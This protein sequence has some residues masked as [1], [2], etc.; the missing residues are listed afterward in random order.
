MHKIDTLIQEESYQLALREIKN[1]LVNEH[2]SEIRWRLNLRKGE[3]NRCRATVNI[4]KA[5]LIFESLLEESRPFLPEMLRLRRNLIEA[6]IEKRCFSLAVE[7][8]SH[9]IAA[10]GEA[11]DLL[12]CQ[13]KHA[14]AI[15]KRL[16]A[17]Y[18]YQRAI[19]LSK[20]NQLALSELYYLVANVNYIIGNFDEAKLNLSYIE[21]HDI[22][23]VKAQRLLA[24][25]VSAAN[26]HI[27]TID[28]L[29]HLTQSNT[30]SDLHA[31]D[32]LNL[33]LA[34]AA[35]GYRN[36]AL[37][38]FYKVAKNFEGCVEAGFAHA[39]ID[40]SKNATADAR[41]RRLWPFPTT[42][43]ERHSCAPAV[44]DLCLRYLGIELDS[45]YIAKNVLSVNGS[46][47]CD[48]V[49]FL[50]ENEIQA[51]RIEVTP[52]RLKSAIDLGLPVIVQEEYATTGHVAVITG[53]DERFD[54]FIANDPASHRPLLKT[55]AWI[56][57]AGDIY[58]NGG[59]I[60]LGKVGQ[61]SMIEE[62]ADAVG[63]KEASHLLML[64]DRQ[65]GRVVL[66]SD[67]QGD[68]VLGVGKTAY[69]E[70]VHLADRAL[71]I[72][73][74]FKL[75]W[76]ERSRAL[77][78][79]WEIHQSDEHLMR[80]TASIYDARSRFSGDKWPYLLHAHLLMKQEYYEEASIAYQEAS[81][82]DP[83]DANA[84]EGMGYAKLLAGDLAHAEKDLLGALKIDPTHNRAARHLAALYLRQLELLEGMRSKNEAPLAYAQIAIPKVAR[85]EVHYPSHILLK[86]ARH[87]A[88]VACSRS[89]NDAMAW[90]MAGALAIR[91][92]RYQ[93]ALK[94]F[95]KA[96]SLGNFASWTIS[97]LAISYE[98]LQRYSEAEKMLQAGCEHF[99][100]L[101]LPWLSLTSYYLRRNKYGEAVATLKRARETVVE[102]REI[103]RKLFL[104]RSKHDSAEEAA[105][106]IRSFAQH[107][108]K[109]V[110]L[111]RMIASL[112]DEYGSRGHAIALFRD[113]VA[114]GPRDVNAIFRLGE[115]LYKDL[116]SREEAETL[117]K[118]ALALAPS[119]MNARIALAWSIMEQDPK[120]SLALV[121]SSEI[122]NA[123][124][125]ATRSAALRMLRR[126]DESKIALQRSLSCY[127]NAQDGR[128][129]LIAWH[130]KRGR[131]IPALELAKDFDFNTLS[132]G[133]RQEVEIV[134]LR[135][136][137]LAGAVSTIIEDVRHRCPDG[138]IQPHLAEEIY[139]G[140]IRHDDNLAAKAAMVMAS[141]SQ[142]QNDALIWRIRAAGCLARKGDISLLVELEDV[143][144]D[145]AEAW[146]EISIAAGSA[147]LEERSLDAAL[148]A[149]QLD[150]GNLHVLAALEAAYRR[151]GKAQRA[152]EIAITIREK[153]PYSSIGNARSATLLARMGKIQEAKGYALSALD[154]APYREDVQAAAAVV[155]FMDR[156]YKKAITHAKAR[157]AMAP[158][159][160]DD[161]ASL[162][163]LKALEGDK[164]AIDRGLTDTIKKTYPLFA[165]LISEVAN[166]VVS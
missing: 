70:V 114:T 53:Y 122:D 153:F 130:Q 10:H 40:A 155:C 54:L 76:H 44:I 18:L 145:N 165:E 6:Y 28:V 105:I 89:P 150:R 135:S 65:R 97:G 19:Y 160:R 93:A 143:A 117:F 69:E 129:A 63:L 47:M 21:S 30:K 138:R 102:K 95:N 84:L 154:S 161:R 60:V 164:E 42:Q 139:L 50:V 62:K 34:Y 38:I 1:R 137:R 31:T 166:R 59:V 39:R 66:Q 61:V 79:L 140:L 36:D 81:F 29:S 22:Y 64:D 92:E 74:N 98:H 112:L 157:E 72:S 159:L 149:K 78:G 91:Q 156:D 35:H 152:L 71:A 86:R 2:D 85:T 25:V 55:S 33:A 7:A 80:A 67:S 132:A 90:S 100:T 158:S 162:L 12:I 104:L 109:N 16:E 110:A 103:V 128:I 126:R 13:A 146:K 15:D 51:R 111:L 24:A 94:A 107:Q 163:V 41:Y 148:R 9:A 77:I 101:D 151:I 88:A 121:E 45:D 75:A 5:I 8:E 133:K 141:K 11:P 136:Y 73:E 144:N 125:W 49:D 120:Q 14:L 27:K 46:R 118:K 113:L 37:S 119:M 134:W 23:W 142:N 147:C 106:E 115:L 68:F 127:G 82:C 96:L 99:S 3:L 87:F 124:L 32:L 26:D 108:R 48:V 52:E 57:R 20:K 56:K 58:G 131:F 123:R 17:L 83:D 4:D 116:S 43:Q